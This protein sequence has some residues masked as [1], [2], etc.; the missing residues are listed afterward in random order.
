MSADKPTPAVYRRRRL[1]A[2]VAL[3]VTIALLWWGIA[4]L[5]GSGGSSDPTP[6][7]TAAAAEPAPA[8]TPA[9]EPTP[10]ATEQPT[11]EP[12]PEPTSEPAAEPQAC[13]PAQVTVSARTDAEFYGADAQ[14]QFSFHLANTS[15]TPCILDV[16]TAAQEFKVTSGSDVIWVSTHCQVEPASQLV[17]LEPGHEQDAPAITWVRERSTPDTCE[18][19]RPSAV[20]GGSYYNLTVTVGGISSGPTTFVLE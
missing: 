3:L 4:A 2:L 6:S 19:E 16:G 18:G 11:A 9:S 5:V 17:Q 14:P 7:P 15:D 10:A 1:V 20:A 13:T 12:E 8:T